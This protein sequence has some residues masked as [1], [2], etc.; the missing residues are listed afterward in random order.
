MFCDPDTKISPSMGSLY[1]YFQVPRVLEKRRGTNK[2]HILYFIHSALF[3]FCFHNN[4]SPLT[5][6]HVKSLVNSSPES[7][8]GTILRGNSD[9]IFRQ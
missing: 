3:V 7:I 1:N 4:T 5:L 2:Q 6:Y 8:Q 9:T